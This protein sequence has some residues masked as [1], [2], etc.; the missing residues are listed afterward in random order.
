MDRQAEGKVDKL[1]KKMSLKKLNVYWQSGSK[2]INE[3]FISE[4]D[5]H[6]EKA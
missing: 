4:L 2:S 6:A 1:L 5:N 3:P